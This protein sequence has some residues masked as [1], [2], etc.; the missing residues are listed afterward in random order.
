[1]ISLFS[2][3]ILVKEF[4]KYRY[5][6]FDEQGYF[7]DP[8]YPMCFHDDQNKKVKITGCSDLNITDN[9]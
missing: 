7:N 1:M 6:V 4:A 9:G 2:G 8:I 3:R 5:G